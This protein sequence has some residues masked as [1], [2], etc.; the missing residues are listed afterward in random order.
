MKLAKLALAVAT[1]A[2]FCVSGVQAASFT[3]SASVTVAPGGSTSLYSLFQGDP[4]A[5]YYELVNGTLSGLVT[6]V[7]LNDTTV[8]LM[9]LRYRV[10]EDAD[11]SVNS[12]DTSNGSFLDII[13][14][15]SPDETVNPF[16]NFVMDAGKHYILELTR[17]SSNLSFAQTDVSAVPLPGAIWLFGSALLGFLGFSNRRK[18]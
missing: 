12:V 7:A 10:Y 1:G 14:S 2:A 5:K 11:G 13:L 4:G 15:D 8:D 6:K 9:D 16:F 3:P 18:I 17:M